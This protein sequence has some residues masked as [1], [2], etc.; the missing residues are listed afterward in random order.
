MA[1]DKSFYV[2]KRKEKKSKS[3]FCHCSFLSMHAYHSSSLIFFRSDYRGKILERRDHLVSRLWHSNPVLPFKTLQHTFILQ[4]CF[5][6]F[7]PFSSLVVHI[8]SAR[9]HL[10]LFSLTFPKPHSHSHSHTTHFQYLLKCKTLASL[11]WHRYIHTFIH[12]VFVTA[13]DIIL[14]LSVV[15]VRF[16]LSFSPSLGLS[17]LHFHF[18]FLFFTCLDGIIRLKEKKTQSN[19]IAHLQISLYKRS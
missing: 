17:L 15:I 13:E 2:S 14:F 10:L 8:R 3:P 6:Y 4:I 1:A 7:F 16:H 11:F 9:H 5:F 19:S 18:F 12:T